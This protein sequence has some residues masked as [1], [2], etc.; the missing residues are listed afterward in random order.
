MQGLNPL[1]EAR[2]AL[3]QTNNKA[4]CSVCPSDVN[5]QPTVETEWKLGRSV[6]TEMPDKMVEVQHEKRQLS[7]TLPKASGI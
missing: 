6:V 1:Y 2:K 7:P 4:V 3:E 5:D